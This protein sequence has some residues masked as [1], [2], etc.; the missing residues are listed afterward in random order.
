MRQFVSAEILNEAR[1][2]ERARVVAQ[3][4]G[5][6]SGKVIVSRF[7]FAASVR[8]NELCEHAVCV[9]LV[10]LLLLSCNRVDFFNIP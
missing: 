3:E 4:L 8:G 6:P 1:L 7:I 10:I 5:K 2:Q 9:P